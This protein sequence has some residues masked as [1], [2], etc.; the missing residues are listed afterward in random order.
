MGDAWGSGCPAPTALWAPPQANP[1][2]SSQVQIS[3][4]KS[5]QGLTT[6]LLLNPTQLPRDV[7]FAT[8]G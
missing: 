6:S 7:N 4:L 1:S 3:G 8:L 5:T 2:N